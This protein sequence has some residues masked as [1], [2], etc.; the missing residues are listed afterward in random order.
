MDVV[1]DADRYETL[2]EAFGKGYRVAAAKPDT[3]DSMMISQLNIY[4]AIIC[5]L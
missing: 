4:L 5:H 3:N 2:G 1:F